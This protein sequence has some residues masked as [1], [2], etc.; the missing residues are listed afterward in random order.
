[1]SAR[2]Y[3]T[4]TSDDEVGEY[5]D[6]VIVSV[7][8]SAEVGTA[9]AAERLG[10]FA[11][12][13]QSLGDYGNPSP[14]DVSV[15]LGD[16]SPLLNEAIYR[17]NLVI[18]ESPAQLTSLA[19]LMDKAD[20]DVL[21][22]QLNGRP[23]MLAGSGLFIVVVAVGRKMVEPL[24]ELGAAWLRELHPDR[25]R[26][27]RQARIR[28]Q[29]ANDRFLTQRVAS[30]LEEPTKAPAKEGNQGVRSKEETSHSSGA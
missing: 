6:V 5:A 16:D 30:A 17:R 11:Y 14:R 21:W 28:Q 27:R 20:V 24:G 22:T 12:R 19:D 23:V 18:E 29:R 3:M 25:V 8:H 2:I 9:E 1:M 4:I 26:A 7:C 15:G 13:Q 10:M